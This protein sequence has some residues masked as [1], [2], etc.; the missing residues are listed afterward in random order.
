NNAGVLLATIPVGNQPTGISVDAAGKVWA[1]NLG[2]SDASRINPATNNVDMTVSL[3]AGAGPYNYSD[4]TG[5]ILVGAPTDGSW[6]VVHDSGVA[7]TDWGSIGWNA[8]TPGDSLLVVRVSS[9]PDGVGFGPES[10]AS[11]G[12]AIAVANNRY[13]KVVVL[14]KRAGTGESPVLFDLSL[15]WL[16]PPQ[17]GTLTATPKGCPPID[18]ELVPMSLT[19]VAPG[20][21]HTMEET[22]GV[23]S[24]TA[25][26]VYEC[27]VEFAVDGVVFATQ[28]I[29]IT[30]PLVYIPGKVDPP[31]IVETIKDGGSITITK[32]VTLPSGVP[33]PM[34]TKDEVSANATS[35]VLILEGTV[36]GGASSPEGQA[37]AALGHTVTVV[38][39]ATWAS[40]TAAQFAAYRA[41][42][43]GDP[44]CNSSPLATAAAN[45]GVWGP[46]IT[47]NV[48]ING[49]DPVYH[50]GQGGG[51]LTNKGVA[52][53]VDEP[54][55]T[56]AYISLSCNYHG[57]AP[58]TA[59]P[60]LDAFSP[61]G[62]TAMGV[63]CYNNAHIVAAHP[64]L[65]GLTDATLSNWSCSVHEAFDKWP[66]DFAVL[67]IAKDIGS[68]YTAPD[69]SVGTPYILARGEKLVVISDI[70]LEPVASTNPVGSPHTLTAIVTEDEAPL[71]GTTVTFKVLDG[72]NKGLIGTGMTNAGGKA[73]FT[74]TGTVVGKDFIVATFVDSTGA[75]QSSS[76]VSKECVEIPELTLTATPKGCAPLQVSLTPISI[77]GLEPGAVVTMDET[78]T[79]PAGTPH[80]VYSCVVE[81]AVNGVV[82]AVQSITIMVPNPGKVEPP[83]V[84]GLLNAGET[85]EVEK[86]ITVPGGGA[87]P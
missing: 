35:G 37:A 66:V 43:L 41:I 45:A 80:G 23:P 56:G 2:S 38:D 48:I 57:T 68:S 70:K 84:T 83:L 63:G 78:I 72:P 21:V 62:F 65:A 85:L 5:S 30:V 24:G 19:G 34:P 14:F 73:I 3:G 54:N 44:T 1:T 29:S 86:K 33:G 25:P 67:A 76:V 79:V 77:P 81:F 6:T 42:I 15:N 59:V 52:F 28:H 47:G 82:F 31:I 55:K 32:T 22:I 46:V 26:G 74:Y 7:G 58:N 10:D 69:G 49:T 61:G 87:S 36:S 71:S 8:S 51:E 20:S 18:V 50:L 9:S 53:A 64:A 60:V 11:N 13:L 40:M 16:A 75:T 17:S 4:M 12:G 39:N 27:V